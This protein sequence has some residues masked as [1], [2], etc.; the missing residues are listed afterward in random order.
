MK[1]YSP[2]ASPV[3]E[4]FDTTHGDIMAVSGL[5]AGPEGH[6]ARQMLFRLRGKGGG[7]ARWE[8]A[9]SE[10]WE[11]SRIMLGTVVFSPP[12]RNPSNGG[13]SRAGLIRV[14]A[15]VCE[16][17][18]RRGKGKAKERSYKIRQVEQYGHLFIVYNYYLI[19]ILDR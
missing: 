7:T 17:P 11:G 6:R 1:L 2:M 12:T 9:G 8:A 13:L 18:R 3:G 16:K 10:E 19:F 14:E 5:V 15:R 4:E